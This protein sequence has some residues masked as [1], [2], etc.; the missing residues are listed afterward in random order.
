VQA[1]AKHADISEID[2]SN[3]HSNGVLVDG[4][5]S[6]LSSELADVK[7]INFNGG[8]FDSGAIFNYLSV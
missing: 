4:V 2:V 3:F 5:I 7:K 8:Y 6:I 1:Q